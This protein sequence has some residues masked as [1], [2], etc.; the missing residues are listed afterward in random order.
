MRLDEILVHHGLQRIL[1]IAMN[2]IFGHTI[3]HRKCLFISGSCAK[4]LVNVARIELLSGASAEG[5]G[6]TGGVGRLGNKLETVLLR[7]LERVLVKRHIVSAL[8]EPWGLL[9]IVEETYQLVGFLIGLSLSISL[10]LKEHIFNTFSV[11]LSFLLVVF[12]PQLESLLANLLALA[13]E[14]IQGPHN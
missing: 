14:A 10:T 6:P 2:Q 1:R 13:L 11:E 3:D 4:F 9:D 7:S 8:G 5:D 12:I